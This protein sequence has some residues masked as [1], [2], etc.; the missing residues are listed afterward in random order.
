MPAT[1][2]GLLTYFPCSPPTPSSSAAARVAKEASRYRD[3]V[4]DWLGVHQE[5]YQKLTGNTTAP[6]NATANATFG[7]A[8]EAA[9]EAAEQE[10][11]VGDVA[12][13]QEAAAD[14]EAGEAVEAE[15]EA[16]L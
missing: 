6:A 14:E 11:A 16:E 8:A 1:S 15:A 13:E 10:A 3:D 7:G 9:A 4:L 2:A 12:A 5:G